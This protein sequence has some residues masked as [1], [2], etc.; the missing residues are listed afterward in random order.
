LCDI[1][2]G[3]RKIGQTVS[4]GNVTRQYMR[5]ICSPSRDMYSQPVYSAGAGECVW[6]FAAGVNR[7]AAMLVEDLVVGVRGGERRDERVQRA[8]GVGRGCVFFSNSGT[9]FIAVEA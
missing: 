7:L 4:E 3:V 8:D 6:L 2:N 1:S 9:C 5:H